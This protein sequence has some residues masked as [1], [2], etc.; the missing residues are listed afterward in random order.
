MHCFI[1][2]DVLT[3][4]L[5]LLI[6]IAILSADLWFFFVVVLCSDPRIVAH[7]KT[8][9]LKLTFLLFYTILKL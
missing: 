1:R 8:S 6:V 2:F 4:G 7:K 9:Y 5:T 3:F